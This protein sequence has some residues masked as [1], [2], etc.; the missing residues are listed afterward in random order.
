[1]EV[2]EGNYVTSPIANTTMREILRDGELY[3]YELSPISGYLLHN[4]EIDTVLEGIEILNEET[5]E[6]EI[7]NKTLLGFVSGSLRCMANYDFTVNPNEFYTILRED[8]PSDAIIF[9]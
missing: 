2:I 5:G 7:V 6:V 4:K 8:A 3:M 1:M 9:G